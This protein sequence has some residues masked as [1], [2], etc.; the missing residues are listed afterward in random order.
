MFLQFASGTQIQSSS[1]WSI[2]PKPVLS[3]GSRPC[4]DPRGHRSRSPKAPLVAWPDRPPRRPSA[5]DSLVWESRADRP[6]CST[7]DIMPTNTARTRLAPVTRPPRRRQGAPRRAAA[8]GGATFCGTPQD[9]GQGASPMHSMSDWGIGYLLTCCKG[10]SPPGRW[11][12]ARDNRPAGV[13]R[14]GSGAAADGPR[15]PER[16]AARWLRWLHPERPLGRGRARARSGPRCGTHP[17]I[18]V[19]D[20]QL[21]WRRATGDD[22]AP[23]HGDSG[24]GQIDPGTG[25]PRSLTWP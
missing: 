25:L 7:H 19:G 14:L 4:M 21:N 13:A 16:R 2:P 20:G 3:H 22:G 6:L 5:S 1:R 24:R 8:A 12:A 17:S 9:H 23:D 15:D 11:R 18:A 10:P